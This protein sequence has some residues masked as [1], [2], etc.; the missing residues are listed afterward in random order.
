MHV[1]TTVP[2]ATRYSREAML[3][4]I[5]AGN[6]RTLAALPQGL[7]TDVIASQLVKVGHPA[8]FP[9]SF[10]GEDVK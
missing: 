6:A 2:T 7:P 10:R 5:E 3:A 8:D 4:A 9:A 1:E